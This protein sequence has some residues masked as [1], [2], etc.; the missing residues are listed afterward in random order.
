MNQRQSFE[1][2]IVPHLD[3]AFNLAR[4]L[5]RS[6]T[7]AE[8]AVQEAAI[9]ALRY[10]GSLRGDDAKPWFLGIVRNTCFTLLERTQGGPD[11]VEFDE[12]VFHGLL[13]PGGT[14]NGNPEDL[15][16]Q[17][18]TKQRV[19]AALRALSP[20][21]REAIILREF[22]D[23]DYAAMAQIM[24]VPIGTVMSRLSRAREKLRAALATDRQGA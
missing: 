2:R 11:W 19:D 14:Q 16:D 18:Q 15:L 20:P 10:L 9:R 17:E 23:L 3:A 8:D 4:W 24:G 22:E 12:Q 7:Q 5:L 21:L 13:G 1:A 6:D